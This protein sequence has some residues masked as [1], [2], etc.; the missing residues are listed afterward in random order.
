MGGDFSKV[1]DQIAG[2]LLSANK[3][4]SRIDAARA[5]AVFLS[6]VTGHKIALS[7]IE[8]DDQAVQ[9]LQSVLFYFLQ[10][11]AFHDAAKL[12][13]APNQF[14]CEPECTRRVWD[15]L[16]ES[17]GLIIPG[18]ASMSKSYGCGV[19]FFL[20]WVSDP[21][22]TTVKVLGP[23]E[24]HLQD[25]LFS[26]LVELWRSSRIPLPGRIGDLFIGLDLR[27]RRSSI[28]GVVIPLGRKPSGRL[29]GAKRFPRRQAHPVHG[30]LSRMRILLDEAENIPQGIWSDVD[31]VLANSEG[32]TG[33]KIACAYNPK[34][35]SLPLGVR[36]EPEGGWRM[37]DLETSYDW[38]SARGWRVIRLDG[39]KSENV[40][41]DRIVFPGLQHKEGLD[42]LA[43]SSGGRDSASYHTFGRGA[44]PQKGAAFTII[45]ATT[46]NRLAATEVF[47]LDKPLKVSGIDL[48]LEGG[49]KA[50]HVG[51]LLGLS[52]GYK[53]P[54]SIE[55]PDGQEVRFKGNHGRPAARWMAY[56]TEM[57]TLDR[58]ETVA[59]ARS[60]KLAA[61]SYGTAPQNVC[62][63]RTGHGAGVHDLLLEIWS[64]LVAGVNFSQSATHRKILAE[65]QQFCDDLYLRLVT[66]LWFAM[67]RW[68]EF[69]VL[70]VAP[71]ILTG[72][73][74][75]QLGSRQFKP[76]LK[77]RVEGKKEYRMRTGQGSPDE[78]DG[79]TLFVHACRNAIP[80]LPTA[81]PELAAASAAAAFRK[82][83]FIIGSSDRHDYLD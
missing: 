19:Y 35:S 6:E 62:C 17:S 44:Y 20:E 29:Q 34:D 69:D 55:H 82:P 30:A 24:Q 64:P 58:G 79:I 80:D 12:L 60:C 10:Q 67:A 78:A 16:D 5:A 27:Q 72:E 7:T 71:E 36:A 28:S 25:N 22:Y 57:K 54:K 38:V 14:T 77:N 48:A 2:H 65:D 18:G 13:W 26:H 33:L 68:S 8:K 81:R 4:T 75:N 9:V 31:N 1:V 49:D 61:Q 23:S 83:V 74:S 37:F 39:E 76:G 50:I 53:L 21:E 11:H 70:K 45:P 43:Q 47:W 32:T 52:L 73:V 56:A 59:M 40:V 3:T 42:A 15:A 66:E 51:G 46:I 41:Q 63:D